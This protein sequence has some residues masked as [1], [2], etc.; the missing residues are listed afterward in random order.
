MCHSCIVFV[1][2]SRPT[3]T[4]VNLPSALARASALGRSCS[5]CGF[6]TFSCKSFHRSPGTTE[7]A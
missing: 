6:T 3:C 1:Q 4:K 7:G 2:F 5:P